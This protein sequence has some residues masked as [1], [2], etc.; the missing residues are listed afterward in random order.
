MIFKEGEIVK[1]KIKHFDETQGSFELT[2]KVPENS[3]YTKYSEG[4]GEV[5]SATIVNATTFG[6]FMRL[7]NGVDGLIYK[8]R[9]SIATFSK[10]SAQ[11]AGDE[12]IILDVRIL[13]YDV[14][15]DGKIKIG[16]ELA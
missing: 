9:L 16:L 13:S 1:A 3:P 12:Q 15:D 4:I 7:E 8:T 14:D 10:M 6:I 11:A 2:M 5:F